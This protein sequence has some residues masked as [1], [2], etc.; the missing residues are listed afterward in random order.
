MNWLLFIPIAFV[1]GSIPF[2]FL[3]GKLKG[4]DIREHGSGNIGATNLGRVL[5]RPYFFLCF[6]LDFSK[7]LTPSLVAGSLLGTLG[8]MDIAPIDAWIWL[9]VMRLK[10]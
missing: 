8:R 4:V 9:A 1:S 3:I 6:A 2:G 7:G 5:G 10:R